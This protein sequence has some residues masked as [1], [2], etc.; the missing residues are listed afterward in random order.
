MGLITRKRGIAS[1]AKVE[2]NA[3]RSKNRETWGWK[4]KPVPVVRG[5]RVVLA[6]GKEY[7]YG[8]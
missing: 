1:R 3:V 5:G 8:A 2:R 6:N 4:P 7:G